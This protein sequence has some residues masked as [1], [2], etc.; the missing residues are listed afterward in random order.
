MVVDPAQGPISELSSKPRHAA[1]RLDRHRH[2]FGLSG[3]QNSGAIGQYEILRTTTA[4]AYDG[5]TTGHRFQ[6]SNAQSFLVRGNH[7]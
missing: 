4:G 2:C 1:D 3:Y 5:N 6:G 7:E